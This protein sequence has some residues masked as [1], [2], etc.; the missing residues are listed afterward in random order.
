MLSEEQVKDL[1]VRLEMASKG[2]KVS[3][4]LNRRGS[5]SWV[6]AYENDVTM[7]VEEIQRLQVEN[8]DLKPSAPQSHTS[9]TAI[10]VEVHKFPPLDDDL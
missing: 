9:P 5:M 7:L 4:G 3:P 10:P 6:R 8:D 1:L 2:S